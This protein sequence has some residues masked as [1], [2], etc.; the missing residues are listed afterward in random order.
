MTPE[1][2]K[3][4]KKKLENM[5]DGVRKGIPR[6]NLLGNLLNKGGVLLL[7][8]YQRNLAPLSTGSY[9]DKRT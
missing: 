8:P 1:G 3:L 2:S 4:S 5:H 6:I 9:S 7:Q